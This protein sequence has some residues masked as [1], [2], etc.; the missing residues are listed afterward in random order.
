MAHESWDEMK[1]SRRWTEQKI[2]TKHDA[3]KRTNN[4]LWDEKVWAVFRSVAFFHR[5]AILR[6]V[7]V[8]FGWHCLEI[9]DFE[10]HNNG[11]ACGVTRSLRVIRYC[12]SHFYFR[13]LLFELDIMGC[14]SHSVA[15]HLQSS[16]STSRCNGCALRARDCQHC[17]R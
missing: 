17:C 15:A 16:R 1:R 9:L 13:S 2:A 5:L 8:I 10:N 11:V 14:H 4:T 3:R 12:I 7:F 6:I